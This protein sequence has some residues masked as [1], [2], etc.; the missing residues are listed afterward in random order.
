MFNDHQGALKDL[1]VDFLDRNNAFILQ[2]HGNIKK[3]LEDLDKVNVF[4]PNDAFTLRS[5]ATMKKMLKDF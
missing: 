3:M 1:N 5:R 4:E 2:S